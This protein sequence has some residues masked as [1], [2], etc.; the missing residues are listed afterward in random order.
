VDFPAAVDNA[1][2][3]MAGGDELPETRTPALREAVTQL[4]RDGEAT[5]DDLVGKAYQREAGGYTSPDSY[6]RPLTAALD[7]LANGRAEVATDGDRY[8]WHGG[9]DE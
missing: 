1:V 6:R 3:H 4:Q 5:A 9:G 8:V 2:S 7:A